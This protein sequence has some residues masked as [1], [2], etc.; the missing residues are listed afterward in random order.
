MFTL[1][2]FMG[3]DARYHS[4]LQRTAIRRKK[5]DL[6]CLALQIV[7]RLLS[8]LSGDFVFPPFPITFLVFDC[9]NE[10]SSCSLTFAVF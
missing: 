9:Y 3:D 7:V 8:L 1:F 2:L 10:R 5:K 6:A 4:P